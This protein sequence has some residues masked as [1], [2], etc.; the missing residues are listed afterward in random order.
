[1]VIITTIIITTTTLIIL[2]MTGLIVRV[3]KFF[4]KDRE[5][6]IVFTFYEI[7]DVN[8]EQHV[9]ITTPEM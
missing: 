5:N 9:N 1:M 6:L 3:E 8:T 7:V 4:H 2:R